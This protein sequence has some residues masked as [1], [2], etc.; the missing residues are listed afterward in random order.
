MI[1]RLFFILAATFFLASC[2]ERGTGLPP[3]IEATPRQ[4]GQWLFVNYWAIW[5]APCREEIPELN[6]F[7]AEHADKVIVYGVN[8]DNVSGED[9]LVQA[10]ELA[11]EFPLLATDPAS[12]LEYARPT[13]LPTTIVINPEGEVWAR[14]LG[15]Q[16]VD[17]LVAAMGAPA[18][19]LA[20]PVN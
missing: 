3:G 9:L 13:V 7:A 18:Q 2:G 5:C 12:Q 8:Y 19:K 4:Q 16:T 10:T 14:L 1:K 6:E 20:P 15:P 17:D 11:I